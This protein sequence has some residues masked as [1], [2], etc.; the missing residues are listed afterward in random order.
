V[1]NFTY[2]TV[3]V[4]NINATAL[5]AVFDKTS[6]PANLVATNSDILDI[7]NSTTFDVIANKIIIVENGIQTPIVQVSDMPEPIFIG[8]N[9]PIGTK[10]AAEAQPTILYTNLGL[11]ANALPETIRNSFAL[12]PYD[13]GNFTETTFVGVFAATENTTSSQYLATIPHDKFNCGQR[14]I[15]SL[16]DTL[17]P[18]F[19][20]LKGFD[21]TIN[22]TG[23]CPESEDYITFEIAAVPPAGSGVPGLVNEDVLLY[24]NP[25]FPNASVTADG[26]DFSNSTN[27]DS[28]EFTLITELPE[29]G[30]V[31]GLTVY[32]LD[33]EWTTTGVDI[34][35][36]QLIAN[37]MVELH[38][39][40]DHIAKLLVGGALIVPPEVPAPSGTGL[41]GVGPGSGIAGGGGD[42]PTARVHR[43]DYDVC[44][45]NISR[46]LVLWQYCC[47]SYT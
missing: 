33:A 45:E 47:L 8:T 39:T 14:Y 43:I 16:D 24:V 32:V 2:V 27:I 5:F 46:I 11:K 40:V 28:L 35:S 38:V 25:Q 22:K 34:I 42:A 20:G 1:I 36:R 31:S 15:Y 19:G 12:A 17:I 41:V 37:G 13:A 10:N 23:V 30:R 29:T 18:T 44:D 7:V 4:S 3:H 21:L 6:D 26:V 9:D